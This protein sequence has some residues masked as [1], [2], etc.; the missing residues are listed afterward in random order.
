MPLDLEP[1][2]KRDRLWSDADLAIA[3]QA[4]KDRRALI[5]RVEELEALGNALVRNETR[6]D[7]WECVRASDLDA[8]RTALSENNQEAEQHEK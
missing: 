7:D 1:I 8:L 2:K 3:D 6:D 4:F 5:E